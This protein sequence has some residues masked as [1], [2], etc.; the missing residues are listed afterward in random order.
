MSILAKTFKQHKAM[1]G[2]AGIGA[3]IGA[4]GGAATATPTEQTPHAKAFG[5]LKGAISG[6]IAGG[7]AHHAMGAVRRFGRDHKTYFK[8]QHLETYK[9]VSEHSVNMSKLKRLGVEPTEQMRYSSEQMKHHLGKIVDL[10]KKDSDF[11]RA[12]LAHLEGL[13]SKLNSKDISLHWNN[14]EQHWNK[15]HEVYGK[16]AEGLFERDATR[17]ADKIKIR[18][19]KAIKKMTEK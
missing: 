7:V 8:N 1:L 11:S 15:F 14:V 16:E 5:A 6:G 3:A 9:K 10:A 2:K 19:N 18:H 13:Q 4:L 12:G 17:R